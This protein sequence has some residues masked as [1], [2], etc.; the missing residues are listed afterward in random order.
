RVLAHLESMVDEV[1]NDMRYNHERWSL[2]YESWDEHVQFLRDFVTSKDGGRV[3][4]MIESA[5][6]AFRMSDAETAH[7]FG[8]LM[9]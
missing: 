8:R 5:K 4:V 3:R 7:Y 9:P 6:R 2:S 1:E